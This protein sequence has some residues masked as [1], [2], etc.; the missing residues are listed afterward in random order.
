MEIT[1]REILYRV[2]LRVREI[3]I[4]LMVITSEE[5]GLTIVR[6]VKGRSI[7]LMDLYILGFIKMG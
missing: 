3:F 2:D 7:S 4:H 1:M 6:M 5:N